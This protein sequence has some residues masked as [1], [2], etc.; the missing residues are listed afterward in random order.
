MDAETG[1]Y[2]YGARYLD[3][4][5]S[6]WISADP[7]LGDYIPGAPVNDEAKKRN[8]NLPGQGGVFNYVNLHLYHY[9]GN[10]PVKYIDPDGRQD[11]IPDLRKNLYKA[12]DFIQK[13]ASTDEE[14]AVATVLTKMMN[15]GKV[16]F[17][18]VAKRY[19]TPRHRGHSDTTRGFF[20][21][22]ENTETGQARNIIVLDIAKSKEGGFGA[23]INTLT[24]EGYHAL[25]FSRGDIA[26]N[27]SN[28]TTYDHLTDLEKPAYD[29]GIRMYNK[30]AEQ[31]GLRPLVAPTRERILDNL[32]NSNRKR[33]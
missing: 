8:G 23:L 17:D 30:Y 28:V 9:A 32:I 31:N 25:Q 21:P 5:T 18:D 1:F 24:H 20:D 6:R 26:V 11:D 12:M 10:N 16:Q 4:K 7:A 33:E 2:Y 15:T 3:P 29:T 13:N 22:F 19:E 14:K 27:M